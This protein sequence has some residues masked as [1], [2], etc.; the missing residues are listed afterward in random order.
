MAGLNQAL[1]GLDDERELISTGDLAKKVDSTEDTIRGQLSKL[2]TKGY[3]DGSSKE[4]W[5]ITADGKDALERQEKIP[6]TAKDVGADTESKLKYYGQLAT[7]DSDLILATSELIISGDPEDLDHVW[8]AMTTMDVPMMARR[9]WWHLWRNYLKQGIPPSLKDKV[10]AAT[11]ENVDEG[12][13]LASV[14]TKKQGRDYI[15]VDDLPVFVGADQGDFSLKDAKDILGMRAIR[16]RVASRGGGG[17]QQFGPKEIM[18][19]LDKVREVRGEGTLQKTY[20]IQPTEEGTVVREV[21]PG[22]PLVLPSQGGNKQ[23]ATYLIDSDGN[24]KKIEPGEPIVI[25]QKGN[26]PVAQKTLV[27]RQTADGIL[28]EE[29]EA[30]KPIILQSATPGGNQPAGLPFPVFGGDGKPVLDTEGKPVYAN[31][32]PT[33]KWLGYQKEQ[34]RADEK[35]DA[36][37]GLVRTVQENIGDGVSALKAAAEEARESDKGKPSSGTPPKGF[38]CGDCHT[39]FYA[40]PGWAG[41]PLICPKC[42]RQYSKEELMA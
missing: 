21:Q 37:M 35:H 25:H 38:N 28:T 40:P 5:K 19:I 12:E 11:E 14:S 22:E 29:Y 1:K 34:K 18:D 16:E 20:V 10:T 15:I 33:L 6:V 7:V 26:P 41:E 9:K 32:E 31:L 39:T 36:L 30:G 2:K 13:E 42:S 4:G 3:V 17:T 23:P 24:T 8:N 27:V